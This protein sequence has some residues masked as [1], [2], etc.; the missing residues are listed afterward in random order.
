M[1]LGWKMM[2]ERALRKGPQNR[3]KLGPTTLDRG[4]HAP[5]VPSVKDFGYSRLLPL[6]SAKT[7]LRALLK[8]VNNTPWGKLLEQSQGN[9][10]SQSHWRAVA[11]AISPP[12]RVNSLPDSPVCL[13]ENSKADTQSSLQFNWLP[14]LWGYWLLQSLSFLFSLLCPDVDW[15]ILEPQNI[16]RDPV[17][18]LKT[19]EEENNLR[20][21]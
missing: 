9:W 21:Y 2:E 17:P 7:L 6:S 15:D 20:F 18:S 12:R 3:Q 5:A 14:G 16:M 8:F 4:R 10:T 13:W 19:S 1:Y 11:R